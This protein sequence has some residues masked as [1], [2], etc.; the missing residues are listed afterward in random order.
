MKVDQRMLSV[1]INFKNK[2]VRKQTWSELLDTLIMSWIMVISCSIDSEN[3]E[4]S[5][6]MLDLKAYEAN[7]CDTCWCPHFQN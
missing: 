2:R 7:T 3:A 5:M 1:L 6:I 4:F